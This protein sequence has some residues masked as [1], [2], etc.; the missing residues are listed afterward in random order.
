MAWSSSIYLSAFK[1]YLILK[2]FIRTLFNTNLYYLF[3]NVLIYLFIDTYILTQI[4]SRSNMLQIFN[5]M[6]IQRFT[7]ISKEFK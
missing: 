4:Q 2:L 6:F 7:R 3:T 5:M 1:I